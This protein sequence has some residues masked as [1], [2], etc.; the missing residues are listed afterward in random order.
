LSEKP[1]IEGGSPVREQP[2]PFAQPSIGEEE[3]AAVVEVLR[4]GWLTTGP[5]TMEFESQF[6]SYVGARHAVAVN[7]CTGALHISLA[8]LDI[9]P[10]DEVI[11]TPFTFAATGNVILYQGGRPVLVDIESDTF[12]ISPERIEAAITKRTKAIIPV[13]Y[14]GHPCD[15]DAIMEIAT[16][17]NLH[18][19]EDAAHAT[20]AEYGE[21]RI[22]SLNNMICFSF[23]AIK[24]MTTGEGGMVTLQ[25]DALANRLRRLRL[26]GISRDAW[27]RYQVTGSWYY[28]IEELG[29][30]YNMTDLQA[31]MGLVQLRKLDN[32][33]NKR[34]EQA[35]YLR[36]R[37]ENLPQIQL[38]RERR[39][40]R[41]AWHL[42]PILLDLKALR[43]DRA[44]FMEA[45]AA[46][47]IGTSVHF[48]P[49]H[50][51]PLFQQRFGYKPGDFPVADSV[52]E[53]I[54]SL[55]LYPKLTQED[56]DDVAA[57][58]TKVVTYYAC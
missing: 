30:K 16:R 57:A 23:Y 48:I 37:L 22:G 18:V 9:G 29:Y 25:D 54:L 14:A 21:H 15:M 19:I 35:H 52:Y 44:R 46:E 17:H 6:K 27:K 13:H 47:H 7:S 38:P 31:A 51:H 11:T 5:N 53:A 4:S 42:F 33:I 32:F 55:P 39:G 12:N 36:R 10:G 26:H 50:L 43:V 34:Q 41:H 49:L 56:L 20:G 8:A 28:E 45:L 58:V 24:N 3:I 1:A 40:I 2:L